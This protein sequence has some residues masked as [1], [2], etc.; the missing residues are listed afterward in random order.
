MDTNPD[1]AV[2]GSGESRDAFLAEPAFKSSD[3]ASRLSPLPQKH[4]EVTR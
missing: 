3:N 1:P 4:S 2:R